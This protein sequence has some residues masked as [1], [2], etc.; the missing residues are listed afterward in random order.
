MKP[1]VR[2]FAG[3]VLVLSF[4]LTTYAGHIPCPGITDEPPT[5][6]ETVISETESGPES[7]A[8]EA[9]LVLIPVLV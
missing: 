5:S 8:L 4:G 1:I 2:F 6:E 7:I 9:L 3:I